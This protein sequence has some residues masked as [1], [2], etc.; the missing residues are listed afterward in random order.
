MAPAGV[1]EAL[2]HALAGA[3]GTALS[4]AAVYPLDL[5]TTRLKVQRQLRREDAIS[6]KDQYRGVLHALKAISS[7]EGGASALYTGLAQDIFKSIA[8]SFLFFLFY[9]YFRD[10]RRR[11]RGRRL[12]VI[13][14][15][16]VG[17]LAGACAR[18]CTTPIA[19]V[20]ARKQTSA[21]FEGNA[22]GENASV[23]KILSS[24]GAENGIAGLWAGYSAS[25]LLTINPSVTFF[26]NEQLGKTLLPDSDEA[27]HN[28]QTTFLLAAASKSI[29]TIISYPLQTA[30]AR[31]QMRGS[32][33]ASPRRSTDT[34][35]RPSSSESSKEPQ[36]PTP[37]DEGSGVLKRLK[38][39]ADDSV[40]AIVLSIARTEGISA[41]YAGLQGEVLK[42]FFSHGLT[43]V[44]K[45]IIHKFV[46][47]LGILLLSLSQ[48][49]S[50]RVR[51]RRLRQV[52]LRLR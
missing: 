10:A 38:R 15:L 51:L 30:K 32:G 9:Q 24:I 22:D 5:V 50:R 39:M 44:S 6:E 11:S 43:M 8:D 52:F 7:Q 20:V 37:V 28:T 18:G 17:A 33:N 26:L 3:T 13:D 21:M 25:L 29:A 12:P 14:E 48:G 27:S 19:N 4:T 42:S 35:E 47:R 1:L 36:S 41:L 16:A 34:P 31:L 2:G 45:G 23:W 49:Q 40:I 46:I